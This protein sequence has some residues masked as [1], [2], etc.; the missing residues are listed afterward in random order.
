MKTIGLGAALAT[1]F[2]T[3]AYASWANLSTLTLRDSRSVHFLVA[4]RTTRVVA[5]PTQLSRWSCRLKEA[6][7]RYT[8]N[9][10]DGN[11]EHTAEVFCETSAAS[12]DKSW[13]TLEQA[14]YSARLELTCNTI[15][16]P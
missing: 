7:G 9:C 2:V 4:D 1:L 10:H 13:L 5:L 16:L 14:D 11:I 6:A 8:L 12:A 15:A 3:T